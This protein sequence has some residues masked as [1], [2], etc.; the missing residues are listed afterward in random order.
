MQLRLH[1]VCHVNTSWCVC[2]SVCLLLFVLAS[3]PCSYACM[4]FVLWTPRDVCLS[5]CPGIKTKQLVT[6]VYA[7]NV[8]CTNTCTQYTHMCACTYTHTYIH[9]HSSAPTRKC[10]HKQYTFVH[11]QGVPKA[12][13][14]PQSHVAS[15]AWAVVR[16]NDASACIVS[17]AWTIHKLLSTPSWGR[18]HGKC[19]CWPIN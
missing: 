8:H 19:C 10:I 9:T 2:V 4:L 12:L 7:S 3:E 6:V 15:A 11:T 14:N 16:I 5:V 1:V 17:D 18:E 13:T